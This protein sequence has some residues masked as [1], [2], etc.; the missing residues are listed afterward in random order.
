MKWELERG[1][2]SKNQ[3]TDIKNKEF[4]KYKYHE[5]EAGVVSILYHFKCPKF[6]FQF[7]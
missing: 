7:S 3:E 2:M 5:Q 4:S 1:K 6:L